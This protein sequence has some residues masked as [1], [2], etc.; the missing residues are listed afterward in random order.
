MAQQPSQA[1]ALLE[2]ALAL[3]KGD[4]LPEALYETWAAGER[5]RLAVQFLS[6]ADKLAEFYTAGHRYEQAAELCHRILAAD[7]CWER[8]YRYLMIAYQGLGNHGQIAR[9]YQRCVQT[10]REELDVSPA[11]ETVALYEQLTR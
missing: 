3:Y 8:A 7:N 11:D 6:A 1:A 2:E 10:L 9:T 5:E 4:Y